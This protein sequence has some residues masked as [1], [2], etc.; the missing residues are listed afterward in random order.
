M[1]VEIKNN[2]EETLSQLVILDDSQL[3]IA[4]NIVKTYEYTFGAFIYI[5]LSVS[6]L[7]ERKKQFIQEKGET[8]NLKLCILL[9]ME[10]ET[11]MHIETVSDIEFRGNMEYLE[12]FINSIDTIT[13]LKILVDEDS[14]PDEISNY[15]PEFDGKEV[16]ELSIAYMSDRKG[17]SFYSKYKR[18]I[19]NFLDSIITPHERLIIISN[20]ENCYI[21]EALEYKKL[22]YYPLGDKSNLLITKDSYGLARFG[23]IT[24]V[25]KAATMPIVREHPPGIRHRISIEKNEVMPFRTYLFKFTK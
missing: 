5:T 22:I 11:E 16:Q 20:L 23:E 19:R 4:H 1:L 15:D 14:S 25:Y 6:E 13:R 7:T 9:D 21:E 17:N 24:I 3:S 10:L 2:V 8:A 18:F 12:R